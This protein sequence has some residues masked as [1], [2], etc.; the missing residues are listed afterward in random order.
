VRRVLPRQAA[1][2]FVL[3]LVAFFVV[4]NVIALV[5]SIVRPEPSGASGSAYATQPRGVAAYAELLR[6]TGHEVTYLRT[7]LDGARLDPAATL[8]V[9][10]A[11]VLGGAERAALAR[12]VRA[13]G[14]LVS[15]GKGA[16]RGVV[17]RPPRWSAQGAQVARPTIAVPETSG[18]RRVVTAG[19]GGFTRLGS[20]LPVLGQDPA[21]LAVA[22][23]GRGRALL[24]ADAAPLQ[25]RL[26]GRADNAAL[27][28]ALAGPRR[29]VAF[30]ESVHG[31]GRETGLAALPARWRIALGGAVLAGLLLLASR[32]RRLGPAQETPGDPTPARREHVEA[33]AL[34]LRRAREPAV[35]LAPMRA[36]ARAQ[37]IRRAA[38]APGAPDDAV[39]DAA[40]RL[41]FGEDEAAALAGERDRIDVPALGRALARG[42]R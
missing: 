6:R 40:L 19:E 21:L 36:A 17:P 5:V 20:T 37:V 39:R 10:E 15:G 14:R 7:G 29:P 18:V 4:L 8:V 32:A 41:G 35:A 25:N 11:P 31:F 24:L 3:G 1:A 9:L 34:G 22:S 2:R 28:L 42:R 27:G 23:P 38:L 12:F 16:G 30:A 26:L 33:L 13:G